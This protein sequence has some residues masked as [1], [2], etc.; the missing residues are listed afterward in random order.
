[1]LRLPPVAGLHRHKAALRGEQ[2]LA[3]SEWHDED[4]VFAQ[5]N[6]RPIDEKTG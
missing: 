5:A 3:C 1:V 6:G 2:I 4:Q